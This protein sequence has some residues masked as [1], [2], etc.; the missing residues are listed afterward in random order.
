VDERVF[1]EI[2]GVIEGAVFAS[3]Q[4]LHDAGV[5]RPLRAGISGATSEGADSIVLSGGYPEDEDYGELVIYTGHGGQDQ[6]TR[7]QVADQSFDAAG[8]A[9]LVVS[10]LEGLPVRV[11]RG[12]GGDTEFSPASGYRYDGLYQ[13]VS[14]WPQR[15]DDGFL[16]CRY[17]LR[18]MTPEGLPAPLSS[19]SV[20]AGPA[21]R[22]RVVTQR[23]VRSTEVTRRVK[24]LHRNACQ[25]CGGTVDT[26]RGRYA[27]GAHIRPLGRPHDG[28]DSAENVLCLCPNDHVRLDRGAIV[29]SEELEVIDVASGSVA[30]TLREIRSHPVGRAHLA[31]HR[32]LFSP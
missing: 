16:R 4:A 23:L 31:Y 2:P 28:P 22:A 21:A 11:V 14:F 17:E 6:V 13:V 3:R 8:N 26:P 20:P 30:G 1:G 25:I 19:S 7:R 29:I 18:K 15:Y 24:R 10:S 5:H 27:E 32:G 12:A 9:G